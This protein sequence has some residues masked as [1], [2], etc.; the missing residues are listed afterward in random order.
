MK[1]DQL[2]KFGLSRS[3]TVVVDREHTNRQRNK[4]DF[5]LIAPPKMRPKIF[6]SQTFTPFNLT[7]VE[8]DQTAKF[9]LSRFKTVAADLEH[10]PDRQIN[11]F[12]F[13]FCPPPLFEE[14]GTDKNF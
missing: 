14:R 9:G 10:T 11:T 4:N 8:S 12:K 3:K 13:H 1:S 6:R 2:A 5:W 7:W